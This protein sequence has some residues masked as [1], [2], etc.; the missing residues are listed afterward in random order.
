MP[1]GLT[2]VSASNCVDSTGTKIASATA[3]FQPCNNF[4]FPMSFELGGGGQVSK[5]PVTAT[6]TNGVF[7]ITLGD[8][9][10]AKPENVGYLVT[11]IDNNSGDQLLG[12][13]YI[14]QPSGAT[15]NFDTFIPNV[16]ALVTI[17]IGPQGPQG[18]PGINGTLTGT[19]T[20]FLDAPLG[21][22][23]AGGLTTDA[24]AVTGPVL[25]GLR[26]T[27]GIDVD[28]VTASGTV[29]DDQSLPINPANNLS[30]VWGVFDQFLKAFLAVRNDDTLLAGGFLGSGTVRSKEI[31]DLVVP[32]NLGIVDG[33][34]DQFNNLILGINAD[35]SLNSVGFLA[36]LASV[37]AS[38]TTVLNRTERA[39]SPDRGTYF[40]QNDGSG[41]SQIWR[42]DPDTFVLT[43]LTTVG[44][45][46]QPTLSEDGTY[47]LFQSN[48]S[49]TVQTYRMTRYGDDQVLAIS[50][51]AKAFTLWHVD[52][53]GQSLCVGA[54]ATPESGI[55]TTQPFAN[56][57]FNSDT[58]CGEAETMPVFQT[59]VNPA[60]IASFVPLVGAVN[61]TTA[62]TSVIGENWSPGFAN[63]ATALLLNSGLAHRMFI[64]I[65]A[66]PA[67]P[68]S[69]LKQG[70]QPYTNMLAE[71]TAAK[72]IAAGLGYTYG[73]RASVCVHGE[74]DESNA[75]TAYTQDL[76]TWQ[77]NSQ[78]DLQAIT[79]QTLSI[80]FII[81]QLS[82]FCLDNNKT[83]GIIPMQQIA[84]WK[85]APNKI[86]PACATYSMVHSGGGLHMDADTYRLMGEYFAKVYAAIVKGQV[87]T[88]L[89]PKWNRLAKIGTQIV[90]PF[91]VPKPPLVFDLVNVLEPS[92]VPGSLYGFEVYDANNNPVTINS[93]QIVGTNMDTVVLNLAS[94]PG[95]GASVAYAFTGAVVNGV[96][97][98]AGPTIGPRGNLRDS[99]TETTFYPY[100]GVPNFP[101]YNWCLHFKEPIPTF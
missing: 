38:N 82:S 31:A 40:T 25:G 65:S 34:V 26:V 5:Q 54:T 57:M 32:N 73:V 99:S 101:L 51:P 88:P 87:W 24:L 60:N 18:P 27:G 68:Y 50:D 7:S 55:T 95:N 10:L 59:A 71:V 4:G 63:S 86:I 80:P 44:S 11:I 46:T 94:D 77:T 90:I 43:Q 61:V 75:N 47:L 96:G 67:T 28:S 42:F 3:Y 81:D 49:G 14:I 12:P 84:A 70:T 33:W 19:L 78:T 100:K 92:F 35:G 56:L 20:T 9:L 13:G 52:G 97:V 69:G 45:N 76:L 85:Q 66:I 64:S 37:I 53:K 62:T 91:F 8:C 6:I 36:Q 79:G 98:G 15:W 48:R 16:P 17:Q 89:Y 1:T 21:A 22:E 29:F 30:V 23:V 72:S 83:Q 41:N 93:A 2:T 74:Q 39:E 58:I